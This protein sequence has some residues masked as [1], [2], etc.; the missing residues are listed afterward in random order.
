MKCAQ[1]GHEM[2]KRVGHYSYEES[3]LKNV[4]LMNIPLYRCPSCK[5]TEVEIPHMEELHLLL[6]FLLVL[7]PIRLKGEEVRYLRKHLGYTAEDLASFLG[8]SRLTVTRWET[9]KLPIRQDHDKHLRRLYLE[10][11]GEE[12]RKFPQVNK[13]FSVLVDRLPFPQNERE[14]R[15]RREDWEMS[16]VT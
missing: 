11:K 8:L 3:G 13:V 9:G 12:L 4:V 14:L 6:G 7:K 1:C 10:K 16:P 2:E 5:E 15:I